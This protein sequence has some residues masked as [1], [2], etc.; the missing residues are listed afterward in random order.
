MEEEERVMEGWSRG[1]RTQDRPLHAETLLV[2]SRGQI[3]ETRRQLSRAGRR[4]RT[5]E[6][7]DGSRG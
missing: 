2:E 7:Q 1:G 3:R 4:A 6:A 5:E